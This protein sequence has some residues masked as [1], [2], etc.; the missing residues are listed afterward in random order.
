M[1]EEEE[2][3]QRRQE[4]SV[5][6]QMA[7]I[8]ASDIPYSRRCYICHIELNKKHRQFVVIAAKMSDARAT[9]ETFSTA[10]EEIAKANMEKY[11]DEYQHERKRT[12]ESQLA[13]ATIAGK[14][15]IVFDDISMD[16]FFNHFLNHN[17]T[18]TQ[19]TII[20]NDRMDTLHDTIM[21]RI[22]GFDDY[23]NNAIDSEEYERKSKCLVN[24]VRALMMINN[25]MNLP[26]YADINKPSM[27]IGKRRK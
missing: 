7:A 21:T 4:T 16:A 2:S 27:S 13:G 3:T 1:S 8:S 23:L 25:I 20:K 15:V 11:Y 12:L 14:K 17:R 18:R 24:E 26:R 6:S 22:E 10:D 19:N 5:T 9:F